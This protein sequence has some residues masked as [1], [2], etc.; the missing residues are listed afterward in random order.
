M[1]NARS[2]TVCSKSVFSRLLQRRRCVAIANGEHKI[3]LSA[4]DTPS[5]KRLLNEIQG[6]PIY[7]ELGLAQI[8]PAT[9]VL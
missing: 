7:D 4:P 3:I 5:A 1:F 8:T 2:E 9:M 6:K